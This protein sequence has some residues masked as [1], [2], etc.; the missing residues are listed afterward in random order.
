MAVKKKWFAI[1]HIAS[2]S[3]QAE[4]GTPAID[5]CSQHRIF[6]Q[7]VYRWKKRYG[8]MLPTEARAL[9]HLRDDNATLKRLVAASSLERVMLQGVLPTKFCDPSDA[10]RPS[11]MLRRATRSAS[12]A[13]AVF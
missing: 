7:S 11:G 3:K 4:L 8:G 9:T 12:A 13:T 6:E 2:I 5:L 10:V 1:E